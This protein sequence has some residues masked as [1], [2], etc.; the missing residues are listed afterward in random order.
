MTD[1]MDV[2]GEPVDEVEQMAASSEVHKDA[3]E[4][5]LED[6]WALEEELQA[7]GYDTIET[8][9]GH[10]AAVDPHDDRP[11]WGLEHIVPDSD[12]EAIEDAVAESEFTEYDV[13]RS[14]V[15]GR[16]FEVTVLL[17]P[18]AEN[19]V[20]IA[21]QFELQR[22][23]ELI[24]YTR[25]QGTVNTIVKFLDDTVVAEIEHD[26]PEKFFPRYDEFESYEDGWDGRVDV[27]PDED[28][29]E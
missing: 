4:Q 6:M 14:L 13:Y 10:T 15:E 5:T 18:D 25:D 8:A 11:Y 28:D 26:D 17:D 23:T 20:L 2:D 27:T 22:A 1:A 16:V 24:V 19:A 3:W 29:E 7:E 21:S 12:A 9:A